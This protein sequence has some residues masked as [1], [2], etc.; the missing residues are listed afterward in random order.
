MA[1]ERTGTAL[2]FPPSIRA[3]VERGDPFAVFRMFRAVELGSMTVTADGTFVSATTPEPKANAPQAVTAHPQTL[4]TQPDRDYGDTVGH[5]ANDGRAARGAQVVSH[6][7][8]PLAEPGTCGHG[9][10]LSAGHDGPHQR[11]FEIPA[12][13]GWTGSPEQVAAWERAVADGTAIRIVPA[14]ETRER[15]RLAFLARAQRIDPRERR[16]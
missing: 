4:D 12:S 14:E 5:A 1:D 3:S 15:N 2:L 6:S 9:C 13:P 10:E 8:T 7:M 11:T 16:A